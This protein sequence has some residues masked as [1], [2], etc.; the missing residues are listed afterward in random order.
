M[1]KRLENRLVITLGITLAILLAELIGG[2]LSNSL[3]LL[4]DAGHVF[5][6]AFALGLSL[7]AARISRRPQDTRATYGYHRVALV[8]ASVNGLSLVAIAGFIFYES[9]ERFMDPPE[10]NLA[11]MMPVAL[12]GLLANVLMVWILGHGGHGKMDLNIRSAWL[13]VMGDTLSSIGVIVS[14]A[15]IYFTG[16]RMADPLAGLMIGVI[17][18]IGGTRVLRESLHILLDMVPPHL[19]VTKIASEIEAM[20]GV[21]SIHDVHLRSLSHRR[22]S[23]SAHVCVEDMLLSEA[24]QLRAEIER[25]LHDMGV[26]HVLIQLESKECH[27]ADLFCKTCA[28]PGGGGHHHNHDSHGHG[29]YG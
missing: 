23:F 13:H 3:A 10:I 18:V 22:L 9:Y 2:L 15:V 21:R 7:V 25:H 19:D 26:G 8:A 12:G 17:I 6:D 16:W 20:K 28:L 29:S 1:D 11:L 27:G 14:G 4:S 24:G 5:T